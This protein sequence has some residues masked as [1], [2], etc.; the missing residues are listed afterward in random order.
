MGGGVFQLVAYG[1]QDIYLTGNPQITFFKVVYRR[2][3]NFAKECILQTI[4]GN[5]TLLASSQTTGSVT[6][7]RNG[8]LLHKVFVSCEQDSTNGIKGENLILD[9]ELE[10]GGQKIDKHFQEWNQIWNELTIPE[11]KAK[12][13]SYMMGNMENSLITMNG[14]DDSSKTN[15][16]SV[17]VPLNFWFCRNPGLAIPLIALQYH[18]VKIK[19]TWNSGT[20]VSRNG[21]GI[22]PQCDVWCEYIYLDKDERTRFAQVSHEYLIEQVQTQ[23][24]GV[25]SQ[26]YK[27]V[28]NHPVKELIWTNTHTGITNQKINIELNAQE[29]FRPQ[30]K[31]YFQLKQPYD[32]HT[33]IPGFNI[34]EHF[35]PTYINPIETG[36]LTHDASSLSSTA[37]NLTNSSITFDSLTLTTYK[38]RVGDI[39]NINI[40]DIIQG[41][42][43]HDFSNLAADSEESVTVTVNGAEIGDQVFVSLN[44][45]NTGIFLNGYVES[46]NNVKVVI[47]NVS[48]APVDLE[49]QNINVIVLKKTSN[50]LTN[51]SVQLKTVSDASDPVCTFVNNINTNHFLTNLKDGMGMSIQC[52]ARNQYRVNRCSTSLTKEI[53]VYS[54][55][56]KPEEH[57]PS[58]TCNFSRINSVNVILDTTGTIDTFYAVNYNVLRIMSGMAGL[59][60]SN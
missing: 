47:T 44:E 3:T 15:Q 1:A 56:L 38:P 18:E 48:S 33:A 24:E 57:Q 13:L 27:L 5:S 52:V 12:G 17:I 19:F 8:D 45:N 14:F 59:A 39:L 31:E 23:T 60:Y 25:S 11:S 4:I 50:E 36:I 51:Y 21:L 58:G 16:Q 49:D 22:T 55:A 32:Y 28:F 43:S 7:S 40:S 42:L 26:F 6:V 20:N 46:L 35:L 9:V 34:K 41:T 54:F 53:N 29:R 30:P 37:A 2:H 10:I